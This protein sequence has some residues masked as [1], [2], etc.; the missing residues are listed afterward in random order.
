MT[1][2]PTEDP[3]YTAQEV[4]KMFGVTAYTI[5]LWIEQGR[6]EARKIEGRWR[7]PRSE[8]RRV[9]NEEHG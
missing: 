8:I 3:L 2:D 5:R 7:I 9:A 4:A 6:I 1:I